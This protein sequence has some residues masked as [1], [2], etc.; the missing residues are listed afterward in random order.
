MA[1]CALL[2]CTIVHL[3]GSSFA[4]TIIQEERAE[5]RVM[6]LPENIFVSDFSPNVEIESFRFVSGLERVTKQH[7]LITI[8]HEGNLALCPLLRE[9]SSD[10]VSR[11]KGAWGNQRVLVGSGTRSKM[12]YNPGVLREC[13]SRIGNADCSRD[14]LVRL[15]WK[16]NVAYPNPSPLIQVALSNR[17]VERCLGLSGALLTTQFG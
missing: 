2:L 11:F 4:S 15:K 3:A 1:G 6:R 17:G 5:I 12:Q 14:C 7:L 16:L 13:F 8:I 9:Y 10:A